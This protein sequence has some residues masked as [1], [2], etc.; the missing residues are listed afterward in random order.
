MNIMKLCQWIVLFFCWTTFLSSLYC[1][2]NQTIMMIIIKIIIIIINKFSLIHFLSTEVILWIYSKI[3]IV[4]I[5]IFENEMNFFIHKFLHKFQQIFFFFDPTNFNSLNIAS[6]NPL[7][8]L[9]IEKSDYHFFFSVCPIN[10][11]QFFSQKILDNNFKKRKKI[12]KSF[13]FN[14]ETW[15]PNERKEKKKRKSQT[16]FQTT[17]SFQKI[18]LQKQFFLLVWFVWIQCVNYSKQR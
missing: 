18:Y 11:N 14:F 15:K 9:M 17:F 2:R 5:I 7:I 6:K 8:H 16:N 12:P 1:Y 3:I 13:C 4:V 10:F